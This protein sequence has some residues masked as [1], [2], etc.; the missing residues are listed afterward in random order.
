MNGITDVHPLIA[1][2]SAVVHVVFHDSYCWQ[3]D[4]LPVSAASILVTFD[5]N[6][7]ENSLFFLISPVRG[8]YD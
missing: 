4:V 3:N 7:E 2:V 6:G 1:D 8:L 5:I